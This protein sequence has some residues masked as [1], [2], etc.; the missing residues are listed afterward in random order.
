MQH[1]RLR[2]IAFMLVAVACFA[3]MDAVLKVLSG[4][5]PALQVGALR[6]AASL[7]F[8]LASVAV[9]QPLARTESGALGTAPGPRRAGADHALGLRRRPSA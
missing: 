6:G 7:P 4:E 5:L 1:T 8:V 3:G 2:G 9:T